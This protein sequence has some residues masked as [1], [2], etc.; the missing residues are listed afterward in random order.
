MDSPTVSLMASSVSVVAQGLPDPQEQQ[1]LPVQV[2]LAPLAELEPAD[3]LAT[4]EVLAQL[5][6]LGLLVQLARQV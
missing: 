5:V 1:V 6:W 4:T 2:S 3:Q